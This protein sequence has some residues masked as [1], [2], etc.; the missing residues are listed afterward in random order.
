MPCRTES[1]IST[2]CRISRQTRKTGCK[3]QID[4]QG[5]I[6][7]NDLERSIGENV[8]GIVCINPSNP[9]GVIYGVKT[10]EEVGRIARKFGLIIVADEVYHNLTFDNSKRP[11]LIRD[12]I[13]DV[14]IIEIG[15]MSKEFFMCGHK[16]GWFDF[17]N[18]TPEL[19]QL[20]KVMEGMCAARFCANLPGQ[21]AAVAALL[22]GND[23][24]GPRMDELRR[25]RGVMILEVEKIP[26]TTF[27]TPEAAFYFWFGIEKLRTG[28]GLDTEFVQKLGDREAVYILPGS[29]FTGEPSKD[30]YHWFRATFLPPVDMI[31]EGIERIGELLKE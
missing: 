30:E 10:I 16:I 26:G 22:G 6:D 15:S 25:R 5:D 2:I 9:T 17:H 31:R 12:I 3:V 11:P 21:R 13:T 8:V 29:A 28:C 1:W 7:I 27:V 23:F 19:E 4:P 18:M 24:L 14:P 20:E